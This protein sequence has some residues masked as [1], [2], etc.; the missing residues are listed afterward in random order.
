VRECIVVAREE[1]PGQKRLVGYITPRIDAEQAPHSTERA[2]LPATLATH[3]ENR[4]PEYMVPS[5]ILVLDSLPRT[6][7]GKIDRKALPAPVS[8]SQTRERAFIA[9][10]DEKERMLAEIWQQVLGLENVSVQDSFFELGGDSLSSFRVANR[11][12]QK[13]LPLSVRMFFEHRTIEKIV[14]AIEN[15]TA[16]PGKIAAIPAVTR[17]PREAHRRKLAVPLG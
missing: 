8:P 2:E 14:R 12:S 4:L 3:V 11:A 1:N 10:R 15:E 17:V 7:N 16:R 5:I 9:P 6:P 13:G